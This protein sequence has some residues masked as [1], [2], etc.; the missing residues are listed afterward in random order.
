LLFRI[1]FEP[2]VKDE[3][4]EIKLPILT[5]DSSLFRYVSKMLYI[6]LVAALY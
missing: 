6:Y 2:K 4:P 5:D 3:F 1:C